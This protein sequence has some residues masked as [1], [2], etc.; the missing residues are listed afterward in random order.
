MRKSVRAI[1]IKDNKLLLM[2]RNKFGTEYYSLIGGG[3]EIGETAEGALSREIY[4]ESSI[5]IANPRLVIVE[6]AGKMFGLQYIY[7]CEYVSGEPNLDQDSIEFKINADGKNIYK[8]LWV[9]QSSLP[10]LN[11][12]PVELKNSLVL[13]LENGFPSEVSN[14]TVSNQ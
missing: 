9:D 8:P 14:I 7:L 10:D 11:L 4:E 12:L 5:K 6:D 13:Y 1:I 3:I 2:Y